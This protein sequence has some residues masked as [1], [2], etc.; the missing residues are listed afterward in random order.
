MYADGIALIADT[1]VKLQRKLKAFNWS[2]FLK[3]GKVNLDKTKVIMFRNNGK[4]LSIEKCFYNRTIIDIVM[5]YKYQT[6]FQFKADMGA[7]NKR[8]YR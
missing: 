4:L 5:H 2:P 3:N 6:F 1:L 7:Q 8:E